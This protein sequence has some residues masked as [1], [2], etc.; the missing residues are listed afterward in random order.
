MK[1]LLLCKCFSRDDVK[2]DLLIE[3]QF[4]QWNAQLIEIEYQRAS[5]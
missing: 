4:D 2:G 5:A 1:H 3:S